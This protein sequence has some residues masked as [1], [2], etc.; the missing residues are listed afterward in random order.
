[1]EI[2]LVPKFL[3]EAVTPVAQSVGNTLSSVWTMVFGGIDIYAQK[4]HHKRIVNFNKFKEELEQKVSSIPEEKLVEPPLH[5]LGPTLEASKF[6]F[7][8]DELR[9]MFANLLVASLNVDTSSKAHPSFV[10]IIKQLSPVDALNLQTFK[11]KDAHPIGNYFFKLTTGSAFRTFQS[12]VFI[13]NKEINDINLNSTSITNLDRLGLVSISFDQRL[14]DENLYQ[15]FF[16]TDVYNHYTG[17]I[18]AF[19]VAVTNQN[20]SFFSM[21]PLGD[22]EKVDLR[23]GMVSLTPYGKNFIE[24]CVK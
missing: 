13:E 19:K 24:I 23:K 16:D 17:L 12:N 4:V 7:E 10:E 5:M 6:Y 3:D 1:M 15:K 20:D 21:Y 8:N 18:E 2:N 22:V 11:Q 9:S 14:Q